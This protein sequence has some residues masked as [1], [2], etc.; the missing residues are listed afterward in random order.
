MTQRVTCPKC[1]ADLR[2][3]PAG[4]RLIHIV[5]PDKD[6]VVAYRCPDCGIKWDRS[7]GEIITVMEEPRK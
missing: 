6:C 4:T 2:D 5:D 7:I 3:P 1:A